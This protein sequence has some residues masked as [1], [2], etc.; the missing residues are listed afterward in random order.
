MSKILSS[1]MKFATATVALCAISTAAFADSVAVHFDDLDL[2]TAAGKAAL[3]RRIE[4]AVR[5]VCASQ[6]ATGT[7]IASRQGLNSCRAEA[8]RQIDAQLAK[9][10]S[11]NGQQG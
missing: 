10:V 1:A 8:R 4:S 5:M 9:Q 3:D 11:P 6:A 7:R 2:T